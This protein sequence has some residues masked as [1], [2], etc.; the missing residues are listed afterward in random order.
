IERNRESCGSKVVASEKIEQPFI[1]MCYDAQ[2]SGGLLIAIAKDKADKLLKALHDEG[3][4]EATVIG[5]IRGEGSGKVFI[6][7][8]GKRKLPQ[9]ETAKAKPASVAAQAAP[10]PV[11]AIAKEVE[12]PCC[13][14]F[15]TTDNAGDLTGVEAIQ[16]NYGAFLSSVSRPGGLD[17]YTKQAMN[18]ALSVLSKCD[19][20]I[21]M[22]K[23]KA[24]KMGFSQEEI[25]E[26]AW[27]GIAFGG[28]PVMMFYKGLEK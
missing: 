8:S 11:A 28:S 5:H 15:A 18:I 27:M 2:T 25:D 26:A 6:E 20:C 1:D 21:K 19:P 4:A 9:V 12:T 16:A 7:T 17:A 23:V 22:H 14:E 13:V 24:K 10:Q 3:V